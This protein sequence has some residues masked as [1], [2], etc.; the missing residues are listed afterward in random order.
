MTPRGFCEALRNT[1]SSTSRGR[2][3]RNLRLFTILLLSMLA[4]WFVAEFV[5]R[6]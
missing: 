5:V 6:F 2:L 4:G 1:F 3:M